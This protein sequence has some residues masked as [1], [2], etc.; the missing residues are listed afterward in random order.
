MSMGEN[1]IY[2]KKMVK[3]FKAKTKCLKN[4][5]RKYLCQKKHIILEKMLQREMKNKKR[6]TNVENNPARKREI[7]SS[8][9]HNSNINNT[10]YK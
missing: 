6:T 5:K 3:I 9:D 10:K 1:D 4:T 7:S 8:G 2:K